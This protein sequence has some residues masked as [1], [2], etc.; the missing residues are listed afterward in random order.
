MKF[1]PCANCSEWKDITALTSVVVEDKETEGVEWDKGG[2]V[3]EAP[4]GNDKYTQLFVC[5]RCYCNGSIFL[6]R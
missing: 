2:V 5:S 3:S 1:R 4:L 6:N